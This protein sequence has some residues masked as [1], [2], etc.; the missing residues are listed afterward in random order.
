[1][2]WNRE[3]LKEL[4]ATYQIG[5]KPF[6]LLL[7]WGE[8]TIMRYL[9]GVRPSEEFAKRLRELGRQPESYLKLLEENKDRLTPVAYK[10]S[11]NAVLRLLFGEK[12]RCA[13][14]YLRQKYASMASP[15]LIVMTLYYTQAYSTGRN[16][17]AFFEEDC[18]ES[19]D[20]LYPYSD[21]LEEL[22][23]GRVAHYREDN[24]LLRAEEEELLNRVFELL[25]EYGPYELLQGYRKERPYLKKSRNDAGVRV[26]RANAFQNYYEKVTAG[27][28]IEK[29]ADLER[30]LSELSGRKNG[31]R[32]GKKN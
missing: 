18:E 6:S 14:A 5:K 21:L 29:P 11:K 8:T 17:S 30:Y 32:T 15:Y 13:A 3:E 22:T 16:K 7:G 12:T 24:G 23:E 2:E 9:N 25:C 27:F 1:M 4:L 19:G 20:R 28:R 10:K 26:I 31:K